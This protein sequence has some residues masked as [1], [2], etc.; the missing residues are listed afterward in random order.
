MR[1]GTRGSRGPL[2]LVCGALLGWLLGGRV[3]ES[4]GV[5]WAA[6]ALVT[7]SVMLSA[8]R[9]SRARGARRSVE[10]IRAAAHGGVGLALG[11]WGL[12][13]ERGLDL[14][15]S[16]PGDALEHAL[17][18]LWPALAVLAIATLAFVERAYATVTPILDLPVGEEAPR[19]IRRSAG[20]GASLGFTVVFVTSL[21][22]A[23]TQ[24]DRRVD[25]SYFAD[26][27]P[28]E[29]TRAAVQ[30]LGDEVRAILFFSEGDEVH[31]RL[32]PYFEALA[33]PT[34]QVER[35]DHAM[36][37]ELV[38]ELRITGNGVVALT[39]GTGEARRAELIEVGT[40]LAAA[41]PRLRTFDG[42]FQE[43]LSRLVQERREL[44]LTVGHEERAHGARPDDDPAT[45]L[46]RFTLGLRRA[47]V[48][49]LP[50]GLAQGLGREV[51]ANVAVVAVMGPRRPFAPEEVESL[52]EL[53]RRGGRV[54]L[55]V[56]HEDDGLDPLLE[57]LGLR[58]RPGIVH[59]EEAALARSHT[60]A[61]RARVQTSLYA[62]H[63]SVQRANRLARR[64]A[65]VVTGA[66]ALDR[67]SGSEDAA[68][69]ERS[70]TE[71]GPVSTET[72]SGDARSDGSGG[73]Q[74]DDDASGGTEP[75]GYA[76]LDPAVAFPLRVEDAWR[77]L[78]GD[79][80]R[81]E[82]EPLETL[83]L[84]A[85]VTVPN[86]RGRQGRA[87]VVGDADFM[88]D[89]QLSSYLGNQLVT[90]DALGW[91]L[92]GVGDDTPVVVGTTTS[93]ED[94]PIEHSPAEVRAWFWATSFGV[95]LP[96]LLFG[97]ELF[98]RQRRGARGEGTR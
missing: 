24:R 26:T 67:Y 59:A 33:G 30:R 98:R 66:L 44:A 69:P 76:A 36:A 5:V 2:V 54:L 62:D 7:A 93:A 32:G 46:V 65:S 58:R 45:R 41:R 1:G 6:A 22:F 37:P 73:S 11:A 28:G 82:G 49:T 74:S 83:R 48:T 21:V 16:T 56:D 12:A 70:P 20:H 52:V 31:A 79:H 39:I 40:D 92:E 14:L 23:A 75:S 91:L 29:D 43:A 96:I 4:D 60:L 47:N 34:L 64:A 18:V 55:L 53:L 80:Q 61:D 8:L 3:L 51:P 86:R 87:V 94:L 95:P 42:R 57:A 38:R 10:R 27:V 15:G 63:P 77:D 50:L 68:R 25:L 88:G 89:E 9:A 78:D 85:V 90:A 19:R 71:G 72:N 84:M 81:G 13:G 35:V 97:L 17:G